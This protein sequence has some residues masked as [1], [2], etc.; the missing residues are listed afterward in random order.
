MSE[1]KWIARL[2]VDDSVAILGE[3]GVW[4]SKDDVLAKRL[5]LRF[6]PRRATGIAVVM[7]FG[8]V[9]A[10]QAAASMKGTVEFSRGMTPIEEGEIS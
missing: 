1:Q 5:M 10:E 3:D 4:R 8:R 9:V 2:T 7:P 6:D